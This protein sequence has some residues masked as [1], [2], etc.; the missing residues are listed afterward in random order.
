MSY[1][2]KY[3]LQPT[4]KVKGNQDRWSREITGV[5][6]RM[7]EKETSLDVRK[8]GQWEKIEWRS[9]EEVERWSHIRIRAQNTERI[10]ENQGID[11]AV[12][13]KHVLRVVKHQTWFI[14]KV[15]FRRDYFSLWGP[16]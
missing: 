7:K 6:E 2:D 3:S 4:P 8:K 14:F 9:Q 10:K 1:R 15:A 5:K 16:S 13:C 11:A 12:L